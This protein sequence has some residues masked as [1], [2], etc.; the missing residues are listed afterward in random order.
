MK[1]TVRSQGAWVM[2]SEQPTPSGATWLKSKIPL[3]RIIIQI[4]LVPT[5]I[6]FALAHSFIGVVITL[7]VFMKLDL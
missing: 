4:A 5:G 3:I 7:L 1:G 6:Y 2:T